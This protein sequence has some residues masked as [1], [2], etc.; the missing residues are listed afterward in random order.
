MTMKSRLDDDLKQ[1]MR[2]RDTLKRTVIRYVKS[3]IHNKEIAKKSELDE[4]GVLQVLTAQAQ[5]RRD[6]IQ[7]YDD[8]KRDDLAEQ[9][10]AELAIIMDYLPQQ[11]TTDEISELVN[12]VVQ[13]VGAAGPGDMK[14]VMPKLMPLVRGKAD[15]QEVSKMVMEV[16]RGLSG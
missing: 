11:L 3:E 15:G 9:E 5:Q 10:R 1:A 12:Q 7:A 8:A 16:L 2:D 13:E 14:S 4:A 6:S